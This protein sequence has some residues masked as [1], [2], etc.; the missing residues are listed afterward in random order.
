MVTDVLEVFFVSCRQAEPSQT[1]DALV[2]G[3]LL[4]IEIL[5]HQVLS[6][7]EQDE[8]GLHKEMSTVDL[9]DDNVFG[10]VC[11][12]VEAVVG[13]L[14][15][16]HVDKERGDDVHHLETLHDLVLIGLYVGQISDD[17]NDHSEVLDQFELRNFLVQDSYEALPLLPQLIQG[18]L[19]LLFDVDWLPAT[20]SGE[21]GD[22]HNVVFAVSLSA[23]KRQK[24]S[25][26]G[27]FLIEFYVPLFLVI[28]CILAEILVIE[29]VVGAHWNP[30][31]LIRDRA[32]TRLERVHEAIDRG[33]H[34]FGSFFEW[35]I[36]AEGL[37]VLDT[38]DHI[39]GQR[40]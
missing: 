19:L 31:G 25:F 1:L 5:M 13:D 16:N 27:L 10:D 20:R 26:G 8:K 33:S 34:D 18:V 21:V 6:T 23:L 39:I 4:G 2:N 30:T 7:R 24:S 17:E 28:F 38:E 37:D 9:A 40:L 36:I 29:R 14:L 3:L 22:A 35:V 12:E 15:V 32:L 11:E